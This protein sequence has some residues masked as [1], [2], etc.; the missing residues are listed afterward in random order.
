M[1]RSKVKSDEVTGLLQDLENAVSAVEMELKLLEVQQLEMA[2][3]KN[4]CDRAL[5]IASMLRHRLGE[6]DE[7]SG[8]ESG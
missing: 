6:T 5:R 1:P 4:A 2:H 8:S 3:A 7:P